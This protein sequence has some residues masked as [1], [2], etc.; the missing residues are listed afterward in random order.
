M[1]PVTLIKPKFPGSLI[2]VSETLEIVMRNMVVEDQTGDARK[3]YYLQIPITPEQAAAIVDTA[4]KVFISER[5]DHEHVFVPVERCL[6][7]AFPIGSM[8]DVH[9][10]FWAEGGAWLGRTTGYKETSVTAPIKSV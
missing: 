1:K 10:R 3:G 2:D 5:G 9:M 7:R 6:T 8:C 4:A